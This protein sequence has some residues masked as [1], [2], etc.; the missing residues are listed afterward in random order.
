MSTELEIKKESQVKESQV[1]LNDSAI[2]QVAQKIAKKAGVS[3]D[4]ARTELGMGIILGMMMNR[5][6]RQDINDNN[7]NTQQ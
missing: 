5:H 3:I 1:T 4:K 7:E 6:R 2:D